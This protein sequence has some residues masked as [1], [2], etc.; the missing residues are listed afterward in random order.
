MSKSKSF[1]GGKEAGTGICFSKA[2]I[3]LLSPWHS[4]TWMLQ[5]EEEEKEEEEEEEEKEEEEEE[6]L[7][8]LFMLITP[9]IQEEVA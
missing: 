2:P 4:C 8:D 1:E 5:E 6:G 3:L 7:F 9:E